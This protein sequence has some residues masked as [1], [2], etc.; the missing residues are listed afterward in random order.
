M[1]Y[2]MSKAQVNVRLRKEL[3]VEIDDLIRSGHFSSKTEAFS[4]AIKLLIK[5][6]KGEILAQKIDRIREETESYLSPTEAVVSS[7]EEEDEHLE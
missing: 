7:H 3:V 6:Y 2:N 1:V 5:T 4:E